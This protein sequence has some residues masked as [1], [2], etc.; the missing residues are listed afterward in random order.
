MQPFPSLGAKYQIWDDRNV[1]PVWS[2]DGKYLYSH[3]RAGQF[4]AVSIITQPAFAFGSP[5]VIP[6]GG[7]TVPN[8]AHRTYDVMPDG[9]RFI[10]TIKGQQAEDVAGHSPNPDRAQLVSRFEAARCGA[11]IALK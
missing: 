9:K 2:P 11:L 4:D 6:I 10:G 1:G 8:N 5:A 7:L 3:P